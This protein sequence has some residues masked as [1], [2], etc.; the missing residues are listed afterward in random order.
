MLIIELPDQSPRNP[1]RGGKE[2]VEFYADASKWDDG[3]FKSE[4]DGTVLRAYPS[5][6]E[7]DQGD[8]ARAALE[9]KP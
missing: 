1:T 3:Y 7:K 8:Q 4:D 5:S 2:G 9:G 6:I